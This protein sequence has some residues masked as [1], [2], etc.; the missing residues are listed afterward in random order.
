MRLYLDDDTVWP[1]LVRLLRTAGH[2]VQVP[3]DLGVAGARDSVH[4][5][6]AVQGG[7]ICLTR[8]YG[9]F[10]ALHDLVLAVQGHHPGILVVRRDNDPRRN[11]RPRDIVR[12]IA[13]LEA[14][15]YVLN[16]RYEVLNPWR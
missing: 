12:A 10:E 5:A 9:D 2:D 4:L 6:R 15:G 8:N 13:N 11:L 14:A 1:H 7:R 16:D 3:A